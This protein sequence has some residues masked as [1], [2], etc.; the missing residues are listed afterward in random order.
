MSVP[1]V[2]K[3]GGHGEGLLVE[4][5][6]V[7]AKGV[8]EGEHVGEPKQGL[9]STVKEESVV[10]SP[11]VSVRLSWNTDRGNKVPASG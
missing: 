1:S 9:G 5:A 8:L 6:W 10:C 2:T 7:V 11:S 3:E 4:G